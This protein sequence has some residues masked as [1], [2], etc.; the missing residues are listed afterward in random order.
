MAALALPGIAFAQGATGFTGIKG[1]LVS[2][3]DIVQ[4]LIYIAGTL[5]LLLFFWGLAKFIKNA[6]SDKARA[7]GRQLMIWGIIALFVL[8][9]VGGLIAF[10][11]D[12]FGIGPRAINFTAILNTGSGG[13]G[14]GGGNCI[15][16]VNCSYP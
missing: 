16:G 4:M 3:V 11:Q 13:G 5:A 6:D 10:I 14:G 1:Y 9:T 8:V 15:P 7:E 2:I 12:E